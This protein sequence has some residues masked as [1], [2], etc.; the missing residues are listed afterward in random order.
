[1]ATEKY[2]GAALGSLSE[3]EKAEARRRRFA[4]DEAAGV[5]PPPLRKHA[6]P[7]GKITSNKESAVS[8]YVERT[9][10][11]EVYVGN[12]EASTT[13]QAVEEL[14]EGCVSA[15]VVRRSGS[16]VVAA[17]ARFDSAS[18]AAAALGSSGKEVAGRKVSVRPW[19]PRRAAVRKKEATS[20]S[21][22]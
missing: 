21:L 9:G 15:R 3:A 10:T 19:K 12:L 22:S 20:S 6:W 18:A 7:G 13:S 17:I 1:M 8:K 5:P 4:A 11:T 16:G 14:F 2:A